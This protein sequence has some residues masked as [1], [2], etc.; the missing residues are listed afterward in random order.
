MLIKN[1]IAIDF[2]L[3]DNLRLLYIDMQVD[4]YEQLV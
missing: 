1:K 4:I 2:T 3:L